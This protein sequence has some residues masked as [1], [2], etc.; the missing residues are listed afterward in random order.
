MRL[1]FAGNAVWR[2]LFKLYAFF[3]D[4]RDFYE[5]TTVKLRFTDTR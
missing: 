3:A 5:I 1:Q 4:E 2:L